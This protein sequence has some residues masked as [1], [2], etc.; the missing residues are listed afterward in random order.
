MT[1]QKKE[2]TALLQRG[3]TTPDCTLGTWNAVNFTIFNVSEPSWE[4]E[5]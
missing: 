1:W 3:E 4:T 5:R 2:T